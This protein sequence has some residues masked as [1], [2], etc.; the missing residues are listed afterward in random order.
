MSSEAIQVVAGDRKTLTPA[1]HYVEN[2][3]IEN[4]ATLDMWFTRAVYVSGVGTRITHNQIQYSKSSGVVFEGNDLICEYNQIAHIGTEADEAVGWTMYG[5]PSFR[6]CIVRYNYFADFNRGSLHG[7]IG[8]RC[9]D[10]VSGVLFYNNLFERCR[11]YTSLSGKNINT[12][13]LHGGKDNIVNNNFFYQCASAITFSPFYENEWQAMIDGKH[14]QLYE[15]V[16]ISSSLYLGRYPALADIRKNVF[17]NTIINN[18][19]I[20]VEK[21]TEVNY[22]GS[23][24]LEEHNLDMVP[25]NGDDALTFDETLQ[26]YHIEPYPFDEVG[27][28]PNSNR[29]LSNPEP[30]AEIYVPVQHSTFPTLA[31][32]GFKTRW[33]TQ[34]PRLVLSEYTGTAFHEGDPSN[35]TPHPV[36]AIIECEHFDRGGKGVAYYDLTPTN[37]F[38]VTLRP[39]A[40]D[41]DLA[42]NPGAGGILIAWA[43]NPEW[44]RYSISVS[45]ESWYEVAVRGG[46][47][48]FG[49]FYMSIDGEEGNVATGLNGVMQR[50]YIFY[51]AT[52]PVLL[53]P[54]KYVLTL[55][56]S[57]FNLEKIRLIKTEPPTG[58][59]S[60]EIDREA[61]S[62]YPNPVKDVIYF[63][64]E[65]GTLRIYDLT[66]QLVGSQ[67]FH[68]RQANIASLQPGIYFIR[69]ET[70]RKILNAKIIKH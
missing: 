65:T 70:N 11:G 32:A 35:V 1:N 21:F 44:Y 16:D 19:T 7:N 46:S 26:D 42:N 18:V 68:N 24:H 45:E 60:P 14:K 33:A 40:P 54:G 57:G 6:G 43:K 9:D 58:F 50:A 22:G 52:K 41:V 34:V 3:L 59:L 39:D 36:P 47:W 64:G 66:G 56:A 30:G 27:I 8:A 67:T 69:L 48:E 62:F 13:N 17:D 23:P 61:L 49:R 51:P 15:D 25:S 37:G 55:L 63:S 20:D 2:N 5:D 38:E 10:Y 28:Q 29:W 53:K 12:L 4:I 31:S